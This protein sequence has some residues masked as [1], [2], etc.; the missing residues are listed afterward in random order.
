MKKKTPKPL[1]RY[2]SLLL[3]AAI[4]IT[5]QAMP[6]SAEPDGGQLRNSGSSPA[7]PVHHCIRNTD[8]TDWS[9][10]YFGS[11]P[12]TE[13][14]GD[15]L[16]AITDAAYDG[17]GDAWVDGVKYRRISE[18]DTNN[19]DYFG[20][21]QY[22]YFKW[23]RI[24]WKVLQNDGNTLFLAADKGLDCKDYNKDFE[25][26]TWEDCPLRSWLNSDF[27]N[28]AFSSGE[29]GAIVEQDV[30]NEDNPDCSTA[31]RNDTRDKVYLL[32]IGEAT[33]PVY[34]FC[35]DYRTHSVS[36]RIQTSDY[37]DVRGAYTEFFGDYKGNGWWL[38]RSSGDVRVNAAD[39]DGGINKD[40]KNVNSD[41]GMCVPALHINLSSDLWSMAD[42]GTHIG[43]AEGSPANP[44]HHC[45]STNKDITDWSYVYF[46]SYPQAEVTGDALTPAITDAAYDGN[47]DAWV[48]GIKY[49]RISKSDTNNDDYFGDAQY[50]Y[51]KWERIKWKVLQ[52]DGSTLFLA[53]DKGLDCKSYSTSTSS[54]WGDC[55]LRSWLNSD[56]YNMAF[57]SDEQGVIANTGGNKVSLLSS[58]EATNPV[59][60][61]C[62]DESAD[63][64]SRR[65]QASDY[66]HAR[67]GWISGDDDK[68]N[69]W[70]WLKSWNYLGELTTY[71]DA[72]GGVNWYGNNVHKGTGVC[73]PALY[74]NLSS[75]FWFVTD[76]GTSGEGGNGGF[77]HEH[78]WNAGE[79]TAKAT[80]TNKGTK[81]YTC[82][83][84][85]G[86]KTE[87]IPATGHQHTEVRNKKNSTCAETGYTG[88]KYCMDCKKIIEA[89]KTLGKA[90]HQYK[91]TV[92]AKAT[93]SKDG[94]MVKKCT[95]CG[96]TAEN[97]AIARIQS[98]K[99]GKTKYV[100]NKKAQKP[101]VTIKDSKGKRIASK[102]YTVTYKNNKKVGKAAVTIQFRGNY[103]GTVTKTFQIVP[104]P[105][106]ITKVAAKA[107]G[108]QVAWKKQ[109]ESTT[110]YQIQYS[111]NKKFTKKATKVKTVKKSSATKLSVK[112]LK[113]KKKYYVR[114]RTYKT[115][116]GKNY[117]SNWSKTK[118]VKTGR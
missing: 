98:V 83:S 106:N 47:G 69:S 60:G 41:D 59:Y 50:C 102:Y 24:K 21:A 6:V 42:D 97:I 91:T 56:F 78:T 116:K 14:T 104:K 114:I 99:L 30:I 79:E 46:G 112:K 7:N 63:S 62:E 67:G 101:A 19:D 55:T 52:N 96:E 8:V 89:G 22:R 43:A 32:S 15:D 81:T 118:T 65:V 90:A 39:V 44:V 13:V 9:Y 93:P 107:K 111:M 95:V 80:C 61:F 88:D 87:E 115:A 17:N 86:T 73:V 11:Y 113:A 38:L 71:V 23:E 75:D 77:K 45:N 35:E 92:T 84:C 20:N 40:G 70:W 100:Y 109:P 68:G 36:R 64:V 94:S 103:E 12:Q 117:Y 34:G 3:A 5:A 2:L 58:D 108:F 25:S 85:G 105:T 27:Y 57:S 31:G 18:S 54:G 26:I 53:A 37:S 82:T 28:M 1:R 74:I 48:D 49:R 76:D 16:T 110:G 51:F 33:N 4:S 29:Q 10:V 66:A 72:G